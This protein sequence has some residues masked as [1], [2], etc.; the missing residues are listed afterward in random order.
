MKTNAKFVTP[1]HNYEHIWLPQ[2]IFANSLDLKFIENDGISSL[3]IQ[4]IGKH[5]HNSIGEINE[6]TLF[7]GMENPL[8]YRNTYEMQ[9]HCSFILYDYPFDVQHCKIVVYYMNLYLS[10]LW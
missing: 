9:F 5:F 10:C 7:T 3:T 1:L 4:Q 6:E 8:I 2:L